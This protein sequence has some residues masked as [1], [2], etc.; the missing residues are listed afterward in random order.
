MENTKEPVLMILPI[1][2]PEEEVDPSDDVIKAIMGEVD[3]F[4]SKFNQMQSQKEKQVSDHQS[5]IEKVMKDQQSRTDQE[6]EAGGGGQGPG[7]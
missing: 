3:S 1:D 2:E 5:L 7:F 4:N 6:W